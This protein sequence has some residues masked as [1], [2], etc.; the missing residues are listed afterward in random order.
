MVWWIGG[1]SKIE[2]AIAQIA[3]NSD[4]AI[5]IIA[6]AVL[7]EHITNAIKKRWRD[8]PKVADGLLQIEGPLGN[9]GP[10]IDLVFLMGLISPEGHQDMK[11]IKKI[12]NKFA[13]NLEVDT[14]ETPLIKGW[15]FELSHFEKFVLKDEEMR[16]PNPAG[17]I[18]GVAGMNEKLQQPKGRYLVAVQLYSML[19]GADWSGI[20]MP[21]VT[22]PTPIY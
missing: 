1:S 10:K 14:F 21:P 6:A 8:S 15:C 16:G 17:K 18:F 22:L 2:Q 7:E 11:I 4:R 20:Y 12:R 19:F 3:R 5:G 13:H 9:F